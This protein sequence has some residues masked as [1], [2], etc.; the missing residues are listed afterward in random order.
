M[1]SPGVGG[2]LSAASDVVLNNPSDDQVLK[3]EDGYWKNL[4][5]ANSVANSMAF[6]MKSGG[7]YANRSTVTSDTSRVVVWIGDTAPTIGGN[8][9]V[10]DVDFWWNTSV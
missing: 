9:A 4:T 5:D 8:G 6:I 2:S 7:S 3:R 10:N 1:G